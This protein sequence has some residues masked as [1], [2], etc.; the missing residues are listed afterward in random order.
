MVEKPKILW[1]S[2]SPYAPTGYGNQTGLFAPLLS[3]RYDLAISSFYGL[4]GSR[5]LWNDIPVYPGL[6]GEYGNDYL[7]EHA[8]RHFGGNPR[9]GL[10]L[11][12]MDVWVLEPEM[13]ANLNCACWVPVDHEP[14]PPSVVN[15]FHRSDAVP[16]AMSRFGQQQLAEVGLD[17]LYMPHGVDTQAFRPYEKREVRKQVGVPDDAFLVGMVAANK[18]RPSRKGFQQAL[19]AFRMLR[20]K[21]ENA[22]LYLHTCTNPNVAQG[23]NLPALIQALGIDPDSV[24]LADQYRML[25]D[26]YPPKTMAKIYS[27][28]D[29]FLNCAHGEG[30]GIPVLEAQACGVPA[31]VTNF[32]AMPEIAGAGWHVACRPQWTGQNSWQATPDVDEIVESLNH[33]YSLPKAARQALSEKARKHALEYDVKLVLERDMLPALEAARQRFE[34]RKPV[35]LAEPLKVAA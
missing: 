22:F 15:F 35:R 2:N 8:A 14:A 33:C 12:L 20:Q 4:E 19:Q 13:V 21:H 7:V 11:T 28:M 23:E 16:I 34:D 31:I 24:L 27:S 25:F 18:G 10:V 5:I 29:V 9:D 1:H 32:S 26:P 30:F 6:G 17:P 3:E